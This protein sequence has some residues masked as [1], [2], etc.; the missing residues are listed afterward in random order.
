MMK[1]LA[2]LWAWAM[3][4]MIIVFSVSIALGLKLMVMIEGVVM[5]AML[6]AALAFVLVLETRS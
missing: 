2:I 5:S 4:A 1:K 6:L 3:W